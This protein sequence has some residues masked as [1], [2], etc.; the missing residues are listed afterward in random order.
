MAF[1]FPTSPALGQTYTLAGI[2][3][4]WDGQK[5]LVKQVGLPPVKTAQA[6][7]RMGNGAMLVSQENGNTIGNVSGYYPADQ[8]SIS[9]TIPISAVAR[10]QQ[11]SGYA[12]YMTNTA[13]ASL[14]AGDSMFF[15]NKIEGNNVNDFSWGAA[16]AKPIVLRFDV[17]VS[18]ISGNY[19]ASIRNA[20]SDR[21]WLGLF[22][23]TAGTW[24]TIT[25]AIPG[26]TTGTWATDTG[27]GLNVAFTFACGS[28]YG[29]GVAGWQ[30]GN[31]IGITGMTNGAAQAQNIYIAN[32]GLHLDPDNT[33]VAPPWQTPDYADE[34]DRCMRYWE[35]GQDGL[36]CYAVSG[37]FISQIVNYTVA[38]RIA[39]TMTYTNQ[40]AAG[41]PTTSTYDYVTTKDFRVYRQANTTAGDAW[42]ATWFANARI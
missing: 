31:L 4:V 19:V 2:T 42:K 6:R 40:N 33:G 23:A 8:W 32:V 9:S 15:L 21:S 38:K 1:D 34:L 7:N 41:F 36:D 24:K 11:A 37:T 5:W 10:Q 39:P 26:D 3:Y 17:Y 25:M 16:A 28:T 27:I 30:A 29:S 22:A 35:T 12:I 13:K 14:I 18:A 20:A